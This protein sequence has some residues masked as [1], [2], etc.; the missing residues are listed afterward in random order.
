MI[1]FANGTRITYEEAARDMEDAGKLGGSGGDPP[2]AFEVLTAKHGRIFRYGFS[3]G[4][5]S[6][7]NGFD[8]T[9]EERCAFMRDWFRSIS[10]E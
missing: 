6:P 4:L 7:N 3:G 9:P 5:T 1:E 2:T 10:G 8:G